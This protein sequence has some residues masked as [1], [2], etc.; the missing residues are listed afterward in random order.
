[1]TTRGVCGGSTRVPKVSTRSWCGESARWVQRASNV[2]SCR[3]RGRPRRGAIGC[4]LGVGC[5]KTNDRMVP[6]GHS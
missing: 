4:A 5:E 3:R 6:S 1:V 2:R